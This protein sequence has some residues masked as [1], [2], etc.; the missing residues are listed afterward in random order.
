MDMIAL[1]IAG[2]RAVAG[3][4][5][6]AF[7][8]TCSTLCSWPR[9]VPDLSACIAC[10]HPAS[11]GGQRLVPGGALHVGHVVT[12]YVSFKMP[13]DDNTNRCDH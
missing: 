2:A 10:S 4:P 12:K 5:V 13:S 8:S 9:I 6:L 7:L 1:T 3:H 11:W